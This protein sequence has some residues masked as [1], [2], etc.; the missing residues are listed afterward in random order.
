MM[1]SRYRLAARASSRPS[2]CRLCTI[3]RT[4]S[5][6][7]RRAST[8]IDAVKASTE[9]AVTEV[10]R[11]PQSLIFSSLGLFNPL[12]MLPVDQL[13]IAAKASEFEIRNLLSP[14]HL[15]LRFAQST[16]PEP[17]GIQT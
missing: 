13:R 4:P 3:S 12:P 2:D 5:R 1:T 9:L 14:I 6:K 15:A 8:S 10:N 17:Q 11:P 16:Q 7:K